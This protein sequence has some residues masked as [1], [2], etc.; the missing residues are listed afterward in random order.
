M[1]FVIVANGNLIVGVTSK[2]GVTVTW[3]LGASVVKKLVTSGGRG[4]WCGPS[5]AAEHRATSTDTQAISDTRQ[6]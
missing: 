1:E 3:S 2:N 5:S 6:T 4:G